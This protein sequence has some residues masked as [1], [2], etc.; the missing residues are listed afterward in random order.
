MP[1]ENFHYASCTRTVI[2]PGDGIVF[3]VFIV[4]RRSGEGCRRQC[5]RSSRYFSFR[6]PRT[7]CA[8][9]SSRMLFLFPKNGVFIFH[10]AWPSFCANEQKHITKLRCIIYGTAVDLHYTFKQV[11]EARRLNF[12]PLCYSVH[13]ACM[14]T[15]AFLCCSKEVHV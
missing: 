3:P 15:G 14:G 12:P 6:P 13:R 1:P 11:P 10:S 8:S 7:M 5:G 9:L 4:A 2:F